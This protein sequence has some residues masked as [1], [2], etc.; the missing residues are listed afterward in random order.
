MAMDHGMIFLGVTPGPQRKAL[1]AYLSHLREERGF[2]RV[3]IPC[4]GTFGTVKSALTAGFEPEQIFTSDVA[5]FSSLLGELFAGRDP[6]ALGYTV[7]DEFRDGWEA[8]DGDPVKQTALA[9]WIMKVA[10]SNRKNLYESMFK[11]HWIGAKGNHIER[12]AATLE[13]MIETFGGV[14]YEVADLRAILDA[15]Y[16]EK[17]VVVLHPPAY[18]VGS[19]EKMFDFGDSIAFEAPFT[20]WDHATEYLP[21]YLATKE[22]AE[23]YIWGR[24]HDLPRGLDRLDGRR[25]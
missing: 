4:C 25:H 21:D 8:L 22:K 3:V 2:D 14:N 16:G 7:A 13:S 12:V 17:T 11:D 18:K 15:D 23:T 20:E 1:A 24:L 6:K 19:Y 10:Q 5:L 9:F